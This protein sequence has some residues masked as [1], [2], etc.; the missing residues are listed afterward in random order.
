MRSR[1][2]AGYTRPIR[3]VF[4]GRFH[5]MKGVDHL[6]AVAEALERRGVPFELHLFGG[7]EL[8][9]VIRA[10]VS[11]RGL[12]SRVA[13]HG[14]VDFATEL[15][16]WLREH[17][18]LFVCCH[19]QGDPSCT[20]LET[21]ACGVPIAGYANE[22]WRGMLR[23]AP[24][25]GVA[26]PM[27]DVEALATAIAR[28]AASPEALLEA[29]INALGFA[30][31]HLFESTFARRIAQLRRLAEEAERDRFDGRAAD[32]REATAASS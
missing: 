30:K 28:L 16:P 32:P 1:V 24:G 7:G 22:A 25:I 26:T 8:D 19:R 18:D 3:L 23:E 11:E 12:S 20:Y 14:S 27:N 29:S 15:V 17:A 2:E 6:P 5:P 9:E 21:L 13:F 31:K 10:R 4:S